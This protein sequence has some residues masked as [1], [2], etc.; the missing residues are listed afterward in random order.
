MDDDLIRHHPRRTKGAGKEKAA[1][2]YQ[3]SDDDRQQKP[4]A[5]PEPETVDP[6]DQRSGTNLACGD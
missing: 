5:V 1:L 3:H 4:A 6:G 2:I